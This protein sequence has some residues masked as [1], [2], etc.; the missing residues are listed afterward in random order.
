MYAFARIHSM[1]Y[2]NVAAAAAAAEW[3]TALHCNSSRVRA[4]PVFSLERS[5]FGLFRKIVVVVVVVRLFNLPLSFMKKVNFS[6]IFLV[7]S[8]STLLN[9]KSNIVLV[10]VCLQLCACFCTI[11]N[12]RVK[13]NMSIQQCY[14]SE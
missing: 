7:S 14:N 11:M 1:N 2:R 3:C 8:V 5:S 4:R 6:I 10:P 9:G 13:Q 12:T